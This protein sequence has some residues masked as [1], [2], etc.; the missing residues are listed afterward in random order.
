[1]TVKPAICRM[2][3]K[4]IIKLLT[5]RFRRPGIKQVDVLCVEG[6]R[7]KARS[8][9]GEAA[10]EAMARKGAEA[11]YLYSGYHTH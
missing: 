11:A 7:K 6:G 4:H 9:N 5:R 3:E 1:M 10:R 2:R 8:L